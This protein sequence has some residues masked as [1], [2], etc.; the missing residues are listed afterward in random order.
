MIVLIIL[1]IMGFM[2]YY[3]KQQE[4]SQRQA[5]AMTWVYRVLAAALV[6]LII[7]F[8]AYLRR[9]RRKNQAAAGGRGPKIQEHGR[10]HHHQTPHDPGARRS[11]FD[12]DSERS[13][14]EQG[15]ERGS[16]EDD[17]GDMDGR[18][19]IHFSLAGLGQVLGAVDRGLHFACLAAGALSYLANLGIGRSLARMPPVQGDPMQSRRW[20]RLPSG[21]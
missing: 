20:Q 12:R 10:H 7:L 18:P 19:K 16:S 9:R 17:H 2:W 5:A 21:F 8:I 14:Y 15:G 13:S 11:D 3:F 4:E 1:G 6:F